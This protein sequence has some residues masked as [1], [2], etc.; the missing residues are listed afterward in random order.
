MC[1]NTVVFNIDKNGEGVG[2]KVF[3]KDLKGYYSTVPSYAINKWIYANNDKYGLSEIDNK[4]YFLGFHT[5]LNLEDAISYS[6]L[7]S[8]NNYDIYKVK[9]RNIMAF[10]TNE[11]GGG[12]DKSGLCIV[13]KYI[14]LVEKMEVADASKDV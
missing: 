6:K 14:K 9:F 4:K 3:R 10:G 7:F 5:F 11:N 13:S 2:Y 8:K 12:L 1:L